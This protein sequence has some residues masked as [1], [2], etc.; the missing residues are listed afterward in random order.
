[1]EFED[2][3]TDTEKNSE[4]ERERE[5]ERQRYA[6]T[7]PA[8]PLGKLGMCFLAGPQSIF[9]AAPPIGDEVL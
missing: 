2:R 8:Q 5:T 6:R 3:Q 4:K 7:K 9:W 1:M